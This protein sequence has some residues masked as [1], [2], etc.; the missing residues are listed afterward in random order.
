MCIRDR[1]FCI[2]N[3]MSVMNTFYNH[4]DSHKWTWYRWNG[5]GRGYEEKSMID[6]MI[7]NNKRLFKDVKSIPSISG[8]SDHRLVVGKMRI[9]G[10]KP[11][12]CKAR[13]R[14]MVEKLREPECREKFKREMEGKRRNVVMDA[15]VDESWRALRDALWEVSEDVVKVKTTH[16]RKKKQTPWWT[17]Q[18]QTA[19]K[20]KMKCFKRWIKTRGVEEREEYVEARRE[21]EQIKRREKES[22]WER[23][24]GELEEDL[25]GTRK[26]IYSIAKSY[27]KGSAPPTYAIKNEN[28]L[29]LTSPSDNSERWEEYFEQLLNIPN[30]IIEEDEQWEERHVALEER[31]DWQIVP[32][33]VE[34]AMRKMKSGKAAGEDILPVEILRG[35]SEG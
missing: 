2:Q 24:G 28:G 35:A 18:V 34:Q 16:G 8:D 33:E 9:D 30:N 21:A 1:D 23:I 15:E 4:R 17:E 12:K 7:T 6:L 22:T 26:L 5:E 29:L 11:Y 20:R 19:V 13:K 25:Q 32:E 27:R 3:D 31:G 14:F 10:V